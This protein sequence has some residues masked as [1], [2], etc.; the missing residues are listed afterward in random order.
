MGL[1]WYGGLDFGLEGRGIGKQ[2]N[3]GL[4]GSWLFELSLTLLKAATKRAV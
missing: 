2:D 4:S 1:V 3:K